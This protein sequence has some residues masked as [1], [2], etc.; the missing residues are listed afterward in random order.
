L[1][2]LFTKTYKNSLECTHTVAIKQLRH[3]NINYF[4]LSERY[5]ILFWRNTVFCS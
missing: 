1:L 4:C 3:K 5:F 2:I